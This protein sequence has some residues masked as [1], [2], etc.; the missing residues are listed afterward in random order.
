MSLCCLMV[1]DFKEQWGRFNEHGKEL[2]S[3]RDL[4]F[5]I[6][7]AE[8][9]LERSITHEPFHKYDLKAFI[10]WAKEKLNDSSRDIQ[11]QELRDEVQSPTFRRRSVS[12]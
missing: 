8:G 6:M 1:Y 9:F 11:L 2:Y 7:Y 4:R 10:A 12:S 3:D 5:G